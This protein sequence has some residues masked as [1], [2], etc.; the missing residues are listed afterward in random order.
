M[1]LFT[2][3]PSTQSGYLDLAMVNYASSKGGIFGTS[4]VRTSNGYGVAGVLLHFD[5]TGVYL[6]QNFDSTPERLLANVMWVAPSAGTFTFY[7]VITTGSASGRPF[8]INTPWNTGANDRDFEYGYTS[9]VVQ[10]ILSFYIYKKTT[11]TT[12]SL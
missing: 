2:S 1:V 8:R 5:S 9:L 7:M 11:T 12:R 10:V 3:G 4:A 6:D